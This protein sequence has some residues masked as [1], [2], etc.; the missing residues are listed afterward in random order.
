[1]REEVRTERDQEL[2]TKIDRWLFREL[3][4]GYTGEAA[5]ARAECLLSYCKY[6]FM[7]MQDRKE[8]FHADT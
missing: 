5:F 2:V 1:M 4:A 3:E 6:L 7:N 8:G